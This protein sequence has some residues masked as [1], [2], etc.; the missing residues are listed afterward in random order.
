MG[1]NNEAFSYSFSFSA[2]AAVPLA[3]SNPNTHLTK[4]ERSWRP[5]NLNVTESDKKTKEDN[6]SIAVKMRI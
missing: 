3:Q 6:L 4:E 5:S 1:R 2:D